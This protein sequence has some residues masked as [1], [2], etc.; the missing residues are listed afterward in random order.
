MSLFADAVFQDAGD[1]GHLWRVLVRLLVA[2][3]LGGLIGLER[4]Q[5]G[6]AAG[7]RTHMLV[8]LGAALFAMLPLESLGKD[9]P[10]TAQQ[11]DRLSRVV[12]GIVTGIG[13]LGAGT[14]LKLSEQ[15]EI[16]GLT[17]AASIWLTAAVGIAVGTGWMWPAI[18]ATV[19]ALLVLAVLHFGER[20]L[21]HRG[22]LRAPELPQTPPGRSR[23]LDEEA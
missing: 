21:K 19:L 1:T 10:P 11:L 6:K 4:Q 23:A 8:G 13:F 7:L 3:V 12:Q 14:I 18:I 20:W 5:E 2:M 9:S 16:K 22:R 15:R 17:T